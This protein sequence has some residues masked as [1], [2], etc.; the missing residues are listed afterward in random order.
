MA[1]EALLCLTHTPPGGGG[2]PQKLAAEGFLGGFL[3]AE[4]PAAGG[5][6]LRFLAAV[7]LISFE[8]T[9]FLERFVIWE[10]PESGF[11]PLRIAKNPPA[12]LLP[13]RLE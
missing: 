6:I 12:A 2:S 5:E 10:I 8:K 1:A 9:T 3:A 4:G 7:R 11:L 13:L